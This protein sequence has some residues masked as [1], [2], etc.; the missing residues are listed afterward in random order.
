MKTNS[1]GPNQTPYSVTSDLGMHCLPVSNNKDSTLIWAKVVR[2][3]SLC[4]C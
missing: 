2:L 1:V 3:L 4:C